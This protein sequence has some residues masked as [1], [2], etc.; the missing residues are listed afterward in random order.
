MTTVVRQYKDTTAWEYD[1]RLDLPDGREIRERRRSKLPSKSGT[2][3][4]AEARARELYEFATTPEVVEQRKVVTLSAFLPKYLAHCSALRQKSSTISNK[5]YFLRKWVEPRFGSL[6]LDKISNAKVAELKAALSVVG[7]SCG[8]NV[9]RALTNL[10]R[11]AIEFGE[12]EAMPCIVKTFRRDSK[13][14]EYYSFAAYEA[15]LATANREQT[16]L[17]LLG[18]EAG[19]RAGEISA[20]EWLDIDFD[21]GVLTIA[22]AIW[23]G[24]IGLPKSN[25]SRSVPMSKRLML[26]LKAYRHLRGP[27]VLYQPNGLTPRRIDLAAWLREAEAAAGLPVTG[28]VHSLRHTFCSHLALAGVDVRTVMALAGHASIVTTQRYMHLAPDSTEN[29]VKML[30]R[31]RGEML[32][33]GIANS[34]TG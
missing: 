33:T 15:L 28:H 12:L 13:E 22:R 5:G 25:K 4:W 29:A 34:V 19:L 3:R 32:E 31:R 6:S 10:L 21:R 26:A 11:V 8:N 23:H 1:I 7:W 9:L 16:I 27:R 14:R 17:I 30:E 2:Q 24:E 20:L 18:A